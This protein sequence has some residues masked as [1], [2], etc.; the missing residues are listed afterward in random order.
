[1]T[2]RPKIGAIWL[3]P[4]LMRGL[5]SEDDIGDAR[6]QY[7]KE[8]PSQRAGLTGACTLV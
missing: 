7:R 8:S 4:D 6:R 3:P 2:K 1:M 5:N